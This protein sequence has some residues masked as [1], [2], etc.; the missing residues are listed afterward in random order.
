MFHCPKCGRQRW[1][2]TNGKWWVCLT[3][4]VKNYEDK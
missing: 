1:H 3:C 2:R 4:K